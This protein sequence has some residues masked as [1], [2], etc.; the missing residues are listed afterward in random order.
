MS[1]N[2]SV[3]FL[4]QYLLYVMAAVAGVVWLTRNRVGKGALAAQAVVGLALLWIGITV[5]AALHVDPRPFVH[6]PASAPLF[7][8]PADNGFPSDHSA[9]AGLLVALV[10]RYQRLI[11]ALL[12]ICAV[13]VAV[14]RVAAHVHHAQDVVAGLG[15]GVV[16][17]ALAVVAVDR[18]VRVWQRR[19]AGTTA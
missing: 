9:A 16:A 5:A 11:G 10:I 15:I 13:L 14:A 1:V 12:G 2:G 18:G 8:H 6:D 4:A 19:T 3:V 7:P 17:G